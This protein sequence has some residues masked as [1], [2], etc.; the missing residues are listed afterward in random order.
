M[1]KTLPMKHT[2]TLLVIAALSIANRAA[3][4]NL[5]HEGF[6]D[7]PALLNNGWVETNKSN[8][9]GADFW[10]QGSLTI[11]TAAYTG[12]STSPAVSMQNGDSI[13][14]WTVS[15]NSAT[16]P[17]RMECRISPNGG[18]AVGADEN[19]VGDFT[20]L[21]FSINADLTTDGY[22]SITVNGDTW[23]RFAGAVTG[24]AGVT[25][26]RVAL[27]YFVTDGGGA[28]SNSSSLGVDELDVFRGEN[29]IGLSERSI[30]GL[31]VSPNPTTDFITVR[32][33]AGA[34]YE[35]NL[36]NL[37]GQQVLAERFAGTGSV[38]LRA[39]ANGVYLLELR[40]LGTGAVARERIVKK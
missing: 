34:S 26:C 10:Q 21:V 33:G 38:D 11:G 32:G 4:Q 12:D 6:D 19:S 25:S 24:L 9:L 16:Y 20:N 36:L 15:F 30:V 18:S 22:P 3:A 7:V 13:S 28:G 40:E 5:L 35:L 8:P 2:Y 14:F 37:E 29:T 31:S 27:R 1:N 17:D 23:T 39:F